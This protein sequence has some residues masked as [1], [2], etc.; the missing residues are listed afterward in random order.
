MAHEHPVLDTDRRFV[1]D[2]YSRVIT[3]MTETKLHLVQ[4][5]HN[6]ER[7]TF[8]IPRYVEEHDM[9][10]ST[11]V[12]VHYLNMGTGTGRNSDV[13]TVEDLTVS[14]DDE[15]LVVFSWLV[16]QNATRIAGTLNFV[17]KFLCMEEDVI[18][19]SWSTTVFAGIKVG[20]GINNTE[21]VA[22][23]YSDVLERWLR[24]IL[25][26][27]EEIEAHRDAAIADINAAAE[28]VDADG[29]V[30]IVKDAADAAVAESKDAAITDINTAAETAK[31]EA[32]NDIK[33]KLDASVVNATNTFSLNPANFEYDEDY[34]E[35]LIDISPSVWAGDDV[36][37][38]LT[39]DC[40]VFIDVDEGTIG[41]DYLELVSS[42]GLRVLGSNDDYSITFSAKEVPSSFVKLQAYVTGFKYSEVIT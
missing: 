9:S 29:A 34:G 19:Y 31:S 38:L 14:E 28:A 11:K 1:I 5:D 13:Y 39:D 12:E 20:E 37:P 4:F 22:E 18:T 23:Q 30:Q 21:S 27:S 8:E 42:I 25:D 7:L 41:V 10:L 33:T 6:S 2:P 16:S 32:I 3:N 15:N 24:T 36:A 35:Y 40:A 17:V 26:S